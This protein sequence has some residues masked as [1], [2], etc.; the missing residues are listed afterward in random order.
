MKRPGGTEDPRQRKLSDEE[1]KTLWKALDAPDLN[2]TDEIKRAIK[3]VLVTAQRPGEV[4]G[5]HT[6]EIDGHWWTIP[7]SRAKN[8]LAHRVY[9]T[10]TALSLLGGTSGKGYIFKTAGKEDLPM[11]ELAMNTAIRRHLLWPLKDA[12]GNPLYNKDGKPAT[13]NRLGVDHL[14]PHDLRRTAATGIS[15][16]DFVDEHVDALLNHKKAGIKRVYILNKYDKEK[17]MML[18]AWERKLTSIIT[19]K[20]NKVISI[21]AGKKAA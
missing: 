11:T 1:I 20:E 9:L 6:E 19:G 21:N 5:M 2:M 7:A 12:K 18:E 17:Q 14:T 8:G 10:Q 15:N 4:I 16:L 13:E 3:L